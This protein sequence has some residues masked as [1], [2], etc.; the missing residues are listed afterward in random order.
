MMNF[1]MWGSGALSMIL[2][3]IVIVVLAILVL[4]GVFTSPPERHVEVKRKRSPAALAKERYAR[5]EISREEY[6]TILDDLK[7][8]Q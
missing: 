8:L 4:R 6:Q 3:W 7:E 1:G 5:G 2:F